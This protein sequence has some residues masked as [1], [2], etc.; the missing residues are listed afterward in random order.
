[1]KDSA[2]ELRKALFTF[3]K[4]HKGKPV[5]VGGMWSGDFIGTVVSHGATEATF[6][7]EKPLNGTVDSDTYTFPYGTYMTLR[8][9]TDAERQVTISEV[10]G[11][12]EV[13]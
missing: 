12:I 1:M 13:A 5:F 6:H 9:L 8:E 3:C 7:V 10:V 11:D 4:T 2:A